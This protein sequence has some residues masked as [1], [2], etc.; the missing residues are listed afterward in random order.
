MAGSNY[1]FMKNDIFRYI[2][3]V[4]A[5]LTFAVQGHARTAT[6][7]FKAAPEGQIALLT[8][9]TRLDMI[10][11]FDFGSDHDSKNALNGQ[12][13]LTRVSDT[14]IAFV[15]DSDIDMQLV[16]LPAKNDTILAL[17]TTIHSP[18]AD[19]SIEFFDSSWNRLKRTPFAMPAYKD[20]LTAEGKRDLTSVEMYLPFIS[21]KA[22]F[23]PDVRRL[24]LENM[25]GE[26][27]D[28]EDYKKVKDLIVPQKKYDVS[29]GRFVLK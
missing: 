29:A 23:E 15:V 12:A 22:S 3:L 20:W 14:D 25:A 11:Y 19:S 21:V 16:V 8:A 17:V 26:Y 5:A 13:R 9:P 6:D 10:D 1:N 2:A 7:F 18:V 4:C 28:E 24:T 27:L